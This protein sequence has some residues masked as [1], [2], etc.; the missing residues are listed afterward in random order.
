ML[1]RNKKDGRRW[2]R[3]RDW[4]SELGAVAAE[5]AVALPVVTM[6]IAIL[7]SVTS[8]QLQRIE[9]AVVASQA[10]RASAIGEGF[11][12]PAGI[13]V[14]DATGTASLRCV[15]ARRE[16][17]IPVLNKAIALGETSCSKGL[18]S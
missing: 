8:G 6:L 2:K 3:G 18:G 10:A 17:R 7:A 16:L 12:P 11:V 9:L 13:T 1:R 4:H 14:V 15:Q 5:L